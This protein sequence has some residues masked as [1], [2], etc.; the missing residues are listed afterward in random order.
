MK[1]YNQILHKIKKDSIKKILVFGP[2]RSGTTIT[3]FA[4]EKDT[5][6][7]L[8]QENITLRSTE[9][10]RNIFFEEENI[11]W[12]QNNAIEYYQ[13]YST[14][15]S[16]IVYRPKDEVLLSAKNYKRLDGLNKY[17]NKLCNKFDNYYDNYWYAWND[18]EHIKNHVVLDYYSL[19]SHSLWLKKKFRTGFTIKQITK[20][21]LEGRKSEDTSRS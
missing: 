16:I 12:H 7:H 11:I 1:T 10:Q 13:Q 21:N 2:P 5:G 18:T 17:Y 9:T 19:S 14:F 20:E 4:L 6:F 3:S 8:F 15:L